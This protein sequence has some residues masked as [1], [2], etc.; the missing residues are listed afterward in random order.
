MASHASSRVAPE[1]G[2][3]E[4]AGPAAAAGPLLRLDDVAKA[5]RAGQA[6]V[7]AL[8]GVSLDV[9][10][11]EFIALTGPSGSGKSTLLHICGLVDSPDAGRY[12]LEGRDTGRLSAR[13]LA[14]TRREKIG[15]VFQGFNLVPVLTALENVE[16]PLLLA[17]APGAVRSARARAAIE[18]VGLRGL[19]RR[20][21]DELS[22]G[23]RQRVAIARAL[24]GNP[25]LV[26]ADEPTA[27]L[28]GATASQ[29]IDLMRELGRTRSVTFLVATHDARMAA[30]C[31]RVVALKDGVLT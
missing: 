6:T 2:E 25:K 30:Q 18:A 12:Q 8:R 24:A 16:V 17:G 23:Q 26:L 1:P 31:D 3:E 11:G 27:N 5:Y 9:G 10:E 21:P 28:D 19:E 20:R 7:Q 14:M 15:F 22:G 4:A 13:E 29:M